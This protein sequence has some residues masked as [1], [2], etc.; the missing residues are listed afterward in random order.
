MKDE[1]VDGVTHDIVVFESRVLLHLAVGGRACE[2]G[3]YFLCVQCRV[4]YNN[5][6]TLISW[7]DDYIGA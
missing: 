7:F 4:P 1:A 5:N 3:L 6:P 2:L